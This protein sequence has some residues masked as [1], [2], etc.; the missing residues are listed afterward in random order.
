MHEAAGNYYLRLN[1]KGFD[2]RR[3]VQ[4]DEG[5]ECGKL[6]GLMTDKAEAELKTKFPNHAERC[7]SCAFKAG[8]FPNGCPETLL[9]AIACVVSG[10]PFFCH[11]KLDAQGEPEDI[12]VGWLLA[13]TAAD[14]KLREVMTPFVNPTPAGA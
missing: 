2:M 8:T 3:T 11:Q 4:T 9:Q 5:R 14:D 13:V 12:C 1:Q 6:L 10:E 7:K